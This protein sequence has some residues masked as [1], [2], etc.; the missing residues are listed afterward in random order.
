MS[1]IQNLYP[2]GL[3]FTFTQ[4]KYLH[5]SLLAKIFVETFIEENISSLTNQNVEE[6]NIAG[7]LSGRRNYIMKNQSI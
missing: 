3:W 5:V 7:M 2:M 4:I 1:I 6:V